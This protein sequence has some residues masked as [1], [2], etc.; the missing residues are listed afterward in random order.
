M[1][2]LALSPFDDDSALATPIAHRDAPRVRFGESACYLSDNRIVIARAGDVSMTGAF[3]ETDVPD[4]K[5]TRAVLRLEHAGELVVVDAEV[6]R[7]SFLS[8]PGGNG[9]GMGLAFV[10]LTP[11]KRRFLARYVAAHHTT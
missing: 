4:P 3:I 6:R 5:G 8:S 2:G 7:V 11:E 9:R 1:V 10:D